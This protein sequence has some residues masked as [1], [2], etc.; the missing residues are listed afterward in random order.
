MKEKKEKPQFPRISRIIPEKYIFFLTIVTSVVVFF[1][2]VLFL[3]GIV[4]LG[5][6]IYTNY[7]NLRKTEIQRQNLQSQINFWQSVADKYSGYKD[8]YFRI[9]VLEYRLGNF[10]EAKNYNQKALLLDPNFAD[11]KQLEVF[12]DKKLGN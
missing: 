8:S 12:I 10:S 11:A 9:A 5:N 6:R 2:A 7:K 4:F 1:I 3:A